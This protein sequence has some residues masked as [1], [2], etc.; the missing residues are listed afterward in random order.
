MFFFFHPTYNKNKTKNRNEKHNK[1]KHRVLLSEIWLSDTAKFLAT[2]ATATATSASN[3]PQTVDPS[4]SFVIGWPPVV[5][6]IAV[7]AD[8]T[9]RSLWLGKLNE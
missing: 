3:A 9:Q 6:Y 5:N 1:L 2:T 4:V 7:F 8:S